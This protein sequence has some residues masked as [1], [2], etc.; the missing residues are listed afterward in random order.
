MPRYLKLAHLVISPLRDS[1][2]GSPLNQ[3]LPAAEKILGKLM[4]RKVDCEQCGAKILVETYERTGGLCAPCKKQRLEELESGLCPNSPNPY[5]QKHGPL[6][7]YLVTALALGIGYWREGYNRYT[8]VTALLFLVCG[9]YLRGRL[10][11]Q[12]AV[13][14]YARFRHQDGNTFGRI[15]FD[16]ISVLC[17]LW[18]AGL[19]FGLFRYGGA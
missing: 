7:L 14:G 8:F 9:P 13:F 15:A 10:K 18:A 5:V 19:T 1:R 3:S 4:T 12:D 6:L 16:A 17:W 2:K 11:G